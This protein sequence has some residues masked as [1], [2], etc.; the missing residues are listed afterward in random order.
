MSI[1]KR[2]EGVRRRPC[3]AEP[4]RSA[5]SGSEAASLRGI[6]SFPPRT[7]NRSSGPTSGPVYAWMSVMAL[8]S[9]GSRPNVPVMSA[10][11]ARPSRLSPP[12][13]TCASIQSR[14][15]CSSSARAWAVA[16]PARYVPMRSASASRRATIAGKP[17][18]AA[19]RV[20]RR[21]SSTIA[22]RASSRRSAARRSSSSSP[23][24][25][26]SAR[27]RT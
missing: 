15:D 5:R 3:I 26:A 21:P 18:I 24:S 1:S 6:W 10:P 17:A 16:A 13:G 19:A 25:A 20:R 8:R 27:M 2:P 12:P 11:T 4:T 7:W 9:F 23:S 22:S 14:A